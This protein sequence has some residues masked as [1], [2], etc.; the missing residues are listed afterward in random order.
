M[1]Y[2]IFLVLL[3]SSATAAADVYK[4]LT[5]SGEA[6]F[7][8]STC[9]RGKTIEQTRP[10]ESVADPDVARQELER[11]RAYVERQAAENEA[12]KRGASGVA[13]L[14]DESSPPSSWP[15]PRPVSPSSTVTRGQ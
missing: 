13:Q 7:S 15:A 4:C 14:P 12:A 8:D 3:F 5:P 2:G 9:E 10:S 6:F 1:R 11:Q